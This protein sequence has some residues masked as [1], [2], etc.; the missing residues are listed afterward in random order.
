MQVDIN[1]VDAQVRKQLLNNEGG[2]WN[3]LEER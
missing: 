3:V 2:C 1:E